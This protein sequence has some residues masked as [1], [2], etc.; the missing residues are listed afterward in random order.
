MSKA[1]DLYSSSLWVYVTIMQFKLI[2]TQNQYLPKNRFHIISKS[3]ICHIKP[4]NDSIYDSNIE[5]C[6][7]SFQI[8]IYCYKLVYFDDF[9]R[10]MLKLIE[11]QY[12]CILFSLWH[13]LLIRCNHKL[14]AKQMIP[15]K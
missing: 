14:M 10:N 12:I 6:T 11:I 1:Y 5:R 13:F 15:K 7:E 2:I 9:E 8:T 3:I 4:Y